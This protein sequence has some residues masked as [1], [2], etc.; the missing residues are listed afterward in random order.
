[1][2]RAKRVVMTERE[3]RYWAAAATR[4]LR[5]MLEPAGLFCLAGRPEVR[6]A[7]SGKFRELTASRKEVSAT[8]IGTYT[9]DVVEAQ[10]F[11]DL[12]AWLKDQR[13]AGEG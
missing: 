6:R 10:V 12:Q 13:P 7:R 3:A 5:T 8:L 11:E 1:M 2:R 9:P 4:Q